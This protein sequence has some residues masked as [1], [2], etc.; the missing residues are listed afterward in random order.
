M[1]QGKIIALLAGA[2]VLLTGGYLALRLKNAE[3]TKQKQEQEAPVSLI[4]FDGDATASLTVKMRKVPSGSCSRIRPG[5]WTG[6][7]SL[8]I[9]IRCPLSAPICAISAP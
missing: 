3:K 1:K 9:P 5:C 2:V 6:T 7:S 8:P 4:S